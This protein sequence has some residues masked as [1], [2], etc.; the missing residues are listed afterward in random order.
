MT[1]TGS[2]ACYLTQPSYTARL[3]YISGGAI[4]IDS[5][6]SYDFANAEPAT[7]GGIKSLYE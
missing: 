4:Q 2:G 5:I 7:W 3:E 6:M 1:P